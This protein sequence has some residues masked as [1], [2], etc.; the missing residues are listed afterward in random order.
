[1]SHTDK[2]E[3]IVLG[4][5]P[6]DL[7]SI[8]I[9]DAGLGFGLWGF[10]LRTRRKG[11]PYIVGVEPFEPY[12]ESQ[13]RVKIYDELHNMTVQEYFQ[14]NPNAKFHF[15]LFCEVAEHIKKQEAL[16]VIRDLRLHLNPGGLL[17]VSTPDGQSAGAP[18]FSGNV[19][20]KHLC[21]FREKDLTEE[22]FDVQSI[23]ITQYGRVVDLFANLW[24]LLKLG[25]RPVTH[26]LVALFRYNHLN[27]GFS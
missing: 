5:I 3:P 12:I 26:E 16:R 7:G 2:L 21:G 11:N 4:L 17:I 9:L 8:R 23:R 1:M 24:F 15:I 22:G 14:E 27:R 20:N 25:R 6:D 18:M 19:L 10:I 13:R